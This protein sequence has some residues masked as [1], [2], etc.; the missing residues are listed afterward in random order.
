M[1]LNVFRP[2]QGPLTPGRAGAMHLTVLRNDGDTRR[3]M[4]DHQATALRAQF[5]T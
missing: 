4:A 2:P 1:T 5:A 3:R